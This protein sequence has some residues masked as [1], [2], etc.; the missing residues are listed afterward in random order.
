MP[1]CSIRNVWVRNV[2]DAACASQFGHVHCLNLGPPN[3]LARTRSEKLCVMCPSL[4]GVS[5]GIKWTYICLKDN[6]VDI[7]CRAQIGWHRH[8]FSSHPMPARPRHPLDLAC[9]WA[10][11][12]RAWSFGASLSPNGMNGTVEHHGMIQLDRKKGYLSEP[13]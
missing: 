3:V 6:C 13:S 11:E 2:W 8:M 12:R 10:K 9:R 1:V 5:N 4:L 7:T